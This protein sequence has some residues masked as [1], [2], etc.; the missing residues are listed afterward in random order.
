MLYLNYF[1]CRKEIWQCWCD[2]KGPF[3]AY[4]CKPHDLLMSKLEEY[5]LDKMTLSILFDYLNNRKQ[6]TSFSSLYDIITGIP[7][8]SILGPRLFNISI[9]DSFLLHIK[10]EICNFADDTM[11]YSCNKE[12]K[13]I[14]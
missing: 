4:D 10:S 13:T 7:Q 6:I 5:G 3:K 9:S 8:R 11:L 2:P 14:I 1:K 12:L